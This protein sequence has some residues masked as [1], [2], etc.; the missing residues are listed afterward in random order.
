LEPGGF[1][2][3]E[4]LGPLRLAAAAELAAA[5]R[6]QRMAVDVRTPAETGV[7][8]RVRVQFDVEPDAPALA[9][10]R[11]VGLA[12]AQDQAALDLQ[13][14]G[15][16]AMFPGVLGTVGEAQLG[17]LAAATPAP[18]K[19]PALLA[20]A[21]GLFQVGEV[22]VHLEGQAER[23]LLLGVVG[24]IDVL[25]QALA[26][27]PGDA[28]LQRLLRGL[29]DVAILATLAQCGRTDDVVAHP[30]VLADA[31]QRDRVRLLAADPAA[32]EAEHPGLVHE[33][34][35]LGAGFDENAS[36]TARNFSRG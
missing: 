8:L 22:A 34:A 11:G 17:A 16:A 18:P 19:A 5:R 27:H 31:R 33:Q 6:R 36:S 3:V 2:Q 25:V 13:L 23:H 1:F 29:T 4:L 28:Q 26:H 10:R 15:L 30:V 20:F 35:A 24:E 12:G 21:I 9:L 32:I 7:P 14:P